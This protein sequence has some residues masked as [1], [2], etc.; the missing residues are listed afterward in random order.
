MV[1]QSE[2]MDVATMGEII[3]KARKKQKLT[4][5]QLGDILHVSDRTISKWE[6]DAGY[7]DITFLMPLAEALHIDV[8]LLLAPKDEMDEGQPKLSTKNVLDY[9]GKQAQQ[10][11]QNNLHLLYRILLGLALLAVGICFICDYVVY[12]SFTWSWIVLLSILY[13][14]ALLYGML[15]F[16]KERIMKTIGIATVG[17][18]P[19]LYGIAWASGGEWFFY[20]GLP[21]ALLTICFVW[22][23]AL[24]FR[25]LPWSYYYKFAL[26]L[27]CS[28][29]YNLCV[30]AIGGGMSESHVVSCFMNQGFAI[31]LIVIGFFQKDKG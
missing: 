19:F 25:Y 4:Q 26:L 21:I 2:V 1:R 17:L 28:G 13:A 23:L 3:A 16:K 12:R 10:H 22:I 8:E 30:N 6:R 14:C 20:P 7:P 5:K 24:E 9:A 15:F 29:I 31:L 27:S 18:I 11:I